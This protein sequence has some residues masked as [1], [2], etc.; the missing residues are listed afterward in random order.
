VVKF[1]MT[2]DLNRD[3]SAIYSTYAAIKVGANGLSLICTPLY[4]GSDGTMIV[5]D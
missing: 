3:V 2:L 5:L 4:S 1:P